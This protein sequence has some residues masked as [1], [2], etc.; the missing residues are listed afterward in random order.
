M[1]TLDEKIK[2][3]A[4]AIA[5]VVVNDLTDDGLLSKE[6]MDRAWEIVEEEARV[7]LCLVKWED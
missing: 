5:D 7:R 4:E 3:C 6:K 2:Q 1:Q